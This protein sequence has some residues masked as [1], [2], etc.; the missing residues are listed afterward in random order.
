MIDLKLL[1]PLIR[2]ISEERGLPEE[3]IFEAVEAAL[4]AAYK[5]EY[6]KKPQIV[7]AKIDP[8]IGEAKFWQVKIVVD[9]S[10][11]LNP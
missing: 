1:N 10:E 9:K 11:I 4:A 2:Q 6:G 3:K 8:Q 7:R 5:K